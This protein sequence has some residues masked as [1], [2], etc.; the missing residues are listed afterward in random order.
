MKCAASLLLLAAALGNVD[1]FGTRKLTDAL[2]LQLLW[3]DFSH[4]L[5]L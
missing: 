1:A 4:L 2:L 3:S 5:V